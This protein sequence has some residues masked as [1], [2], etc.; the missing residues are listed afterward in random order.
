M[1]IYV[2]LTLYTSINN[3]YAFYFEFICVFYNICIP[4]AKYLYFCI[5]Y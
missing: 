1:Y 4:V 5:I 2:N 3:L